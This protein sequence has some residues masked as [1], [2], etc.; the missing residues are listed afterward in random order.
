MTGDANGGGR[1]D[2]RK[3][4]VTLPPEVYDA[5]VQESARRKTAGQANHLSRRFQQQIGDASEKILA[6][7]IVDI[8]GRGWIL[9]EKFSYDANRYLPFSNWQEVSRFFSE[10]GDVRLQLT[11]PGR[12]GKETLEVKEPRATT[13][14]E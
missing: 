10:R 11:I 8:A 3:L 9:L 5:L 4:T 12:R 7:L 6:D 13:N 14:Q 2:F 1:G